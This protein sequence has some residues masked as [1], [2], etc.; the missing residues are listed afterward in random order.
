MSPSSDSSHQNVS[1]LDLMRAFQAAMEALQSSGIVPVAGRALAREPITSERLAAVL[2]SIQDVIYSVAPDG[3]QIL[4]VSPSAERVYESSL[5]SLTGHPRD[6]FMR[7][8]EGDRERVRARLPE[9]FRDG[10]LDIEYRIDLPSGGLRW[11]RDRM[12]IVRDVSGRAVR[13]DGI[14]ADITA[15]VHAD[16]ARELAEGTLRLKDRA[17]E[18]T[19]NGVVVT[20]MTNPSYPIIY[21]NPGFERITGYAAAD[22]Y[23]LNCGFLHGTDRDQAGLAELREAIHAGRECQVVLRNYRKDGS[24]FWNELSVSPV[25]DD[26]GR[27]THYVGVQN[28]ITE[29][30]RQ[31]EELQERTRRLDAIFSLSPDGFVSFDRDGVVAYVNPAFTRMT[32]LVAAQVI[33]RTEMAFD[34]RLRERCDPKQPYRPLADT[35]CVSQA[36]EKSASDLLPLMIPE[37][38]MLTRSVRREEGG[39]KVLYFRDVTRETEVDRMKSEF[40]TT[41]AHELRTP[42]ASVYGFSELLLRREFDDTTRKDLLSTIHRQ[43]GALIQLLNELL[44]LARIEAR[45][46][47]DFRIAVQ[48]LRPILESTVASLLVPDDP[49]RVRVELP[50]GEVHCAVD[51]EKLRQALTNL[52]SNAYKYS[53]AGG[54]IRLDTVRDDLG[55]RVGIRVSDRGIGMTSEQLARCFERFYRADASGNIPGTGLGLALVKEIVEIQGGSVELRS[56]PGEGTT[57]VVW[58]PLAEAAAAAA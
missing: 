20:D 4:Y 15:Q 53:P 47:K 21:A 56:Q 7:I 18:S 49:R 30:I 31:A 36:D 17:L 33:G 37:R 58:L 48:P 28:D 38:R 57:A 52:L 13:I 27:V 29:R 8:N 23:G 44:D 22:I 32:G 2:E 14:A 54:E 41:A 25:R 43:A 3:S 19:Q 24:L 55:T 16:M 45:A 10:Q 5:D 1:R 6:W 35:P 26:Q 51:A 11:L 40:L 50:D 46:G 34:A 12:Q 9:L 42:M 39:S